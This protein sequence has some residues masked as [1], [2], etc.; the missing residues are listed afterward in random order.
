MPGRTLPL[1]LAVVLSALPAIAHAFTSCVGTSAE[2]D[3]ALELVPASSD[4][5]IN[6]K[7]RPGTYTAG[8]GI[9]FYVNQAHS[10]QN[11][12]IG[13][14]W[15][16]PACEVRS[17]GAEGT[18]LKGS[19]GVAALQLNTGFDTTGNTIIAG[20]LTLR[21]DIGIA[22]DAVGACLSV[23]T[24]SGSTV[25]ASRMR[26]DGCVGSSAAILTNGAGGQLVFANSVVQGGY[27]HGAPV[28]LESGGGTTRLAFLTITG[29]TA[30]SAS[31]PASGLRILAA[32]GSTVTLDSSIV[33]GGIAPEGIPD[34]AT[35]GPGIVFTR[36]HYEAR[37]QVNAIVVDNAPSHGDPGFLRPAYPRLRQDSALVDS[38]VASY[39][40]GLDVEGHVRELGAAHDVG[41]YETIPDRI[42]ADGF[43]H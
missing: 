20:D 27:N 40:G 26:L 21:N 9:A 39:G 34:I 12:Q 2:L 32:P 25:D 42:H 24:Q 33:W 38:G 30:T 11:V 28:L 3:A 31:Q 10:N 41:A 4:P 37:T 19:S 29:N 36:A 14:G 6:I 5:F 8:A 43:D 1:Q 23:I 35:S 16:G 13:G 7:I 22:N 17:H 15:T 18:V